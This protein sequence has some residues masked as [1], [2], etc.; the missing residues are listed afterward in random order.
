MQVPRCTE[1]LLSQGSESSS[2]ASEWKTWLFQT[3][4]AGG[5]P[6]RGRS[7]LGCFLFLGLI[8]ATGW[9]VHA[10]FFSDPPLHVSSFAE[11][12]CRLNFKKKDIK[13]IPS[14]FGWLQLLQ[15]Q[16]F[17]GFATIVLS[18]MCSKNKPWLSGRKHPDTLLADLLSV[19]LGH[20]WVTFR[21]RNSGWL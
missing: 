19:H 20:I 13:C 16:V 17:T 15:L 10:C 1:R 18:E 6:N 3:I 11:I 14:C 5:R 2:G 4:K 8:L 21:L 7:W 9:G 12:T